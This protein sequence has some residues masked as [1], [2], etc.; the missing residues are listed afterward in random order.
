MNTTAQ[1]ITA[2]SLIIAGMLVTF[3]LDE[4]SGYSSPGTLLTIAGVVM[5]IYLIYKNRGMKAAVVA[6][7]PWGLIPI[8]L[9]V[10]IIDFILPNSSIFSPFIFL[11]VIG[12]LNII[13]VI[14]TALLL[15][16]TKRAGH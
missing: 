3:W 14:V 13:A 8:T 4:A 12:W 1:K 11:G 10:L 9:A 5:A 16:I 6:A 2:F 15:F 7:I